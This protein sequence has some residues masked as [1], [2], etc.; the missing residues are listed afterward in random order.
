MR[1]S[2][3]LLSGCGYGPADGSH[4]PPPASPPGDRTAAIVT[5]TGMVTDIVRHVAGK[6]GHVTGIIET[7][8]DP[9]LFKPTRGHIK[10]LHDAD[11]VFYSGLMLE[12]R[13][14]ETFV[15]LERSG[16]SVFA[17]TESLDKE[18]L[19]SPPDFAGHY[20][21]HVW[22][23]VRAWSR[24]ADHVAESLSKVD[25]SHADE[26]RANAK[27]YCEQLD[28]LDNYVRT[29]IQSVP[30]N[31][32][33]LVT[34]HDAFGYF[35]QAYG[36][37]VKSVQGVTTESEAGVL[38]VNRLVDFLVERKLPAIFVESS[39]NSKNIQAVLEGVQSRGVAVQ[40]GG[41]LFSDASGAA[42]ILRRNIHRHD[43]SQRHLDR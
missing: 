2:G 5:T 23:D 13:M 3:S 26:Y 41:E 11:I 17:V 4:G 40:I 43:R 6:Y 22:M 37:E 29:V 27:G 25:P 31:Q 14:N 16:K 36:I 7:G 32:R 42:R 1:S 38:D 18:S 12:G 39:V 9:H 33:V 34:A 20:D 8:I 30:E 35:S 24:C 15:Q 19:R 28:R 21:P 10:Q